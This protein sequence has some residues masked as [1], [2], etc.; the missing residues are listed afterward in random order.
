M[1]R[2]AK[3]KEPGNAEPAARAMPSRGSGRAGEASM[4]V[5]NAKKRAA[6]MFADAVA[7]EGYKYWMYLDTSSWVTIGYGHKIEDA[8][9]AT[10]IDLRDAQ[11]RVVKDEDKKKEWQRLRALSP[12]GSAL[13]YRAEHYKKDAKLFITDEEGMR[14]LLDDLDD[15]VK[16]LQRKFKNFDTFPE[17]AQVALIDMIYNLGPS[18]FSKFKK[19]NAAI[20][21]PKGPDWKKAAKSCKR[22]PPISDERNRTVRELFEAAAK[23][24]AGAAGA[25]PGAAPPA[26]PPPHPAQGGPQPQALV[27]AGMTAPNHPT[28]Q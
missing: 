3:H 10:G 13:N 25:K 17:D 4:T 16:A 5:E 11:K 20:R 19:L 6:E 1:P 24:A 22:Q 2:K 27:P 28:L 23:A 26:A 14:L 18:G 15:F 9:E 21:E 7:G 8:D 12:G